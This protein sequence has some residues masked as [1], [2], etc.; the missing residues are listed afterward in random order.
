MHR[1]EYAAYVSLREQ[2]AT[3]RRR[4]AADARALA[5]TT[6]TRRATYRQRRRD[7]AILRVSLAVSAAAIFLLQFIR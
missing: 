2:A 3:M 5:A 4:A 1:H 6:A 7:A